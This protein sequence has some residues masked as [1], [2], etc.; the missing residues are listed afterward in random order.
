MESLMKDINNIDVNK[1]VYVAP[2]L[3]NTWP[4]CPTELMIVTY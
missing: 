1:I 3:A 2:Q 4:Y